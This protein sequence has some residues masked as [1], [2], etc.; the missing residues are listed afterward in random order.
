MIAITVK[1][2]AERGADSGRIF[3]RL[4]S[5]TRMATV[6]S[7]LCLRSEDWDSKSSTVAIGNSDVRLMI[8]R[9]IIHRDVTNLR[10]IIGRLG[11]DRPSF[12]LGD[13]K[14]EF[15][16]FV[17]RYS[18]VSYMTDVIANLRQTGHRRTAETYLTALN[19]FQSFLD[20]CSMQEILIT[21]ENFTI[22]CLTQRIMQEFQSWLITQGLI[23][24][25]IS[26]YNRIL[27]ATYN[28]AVDEGAI[29]NTNPF[30]HVY[31]GVYATMK[32]ALSIDDIRAIRGLDLANYPQLDLARDMFLMSFYLR[33]MSLIDMSF[34]RKSDLV[35]GYIIYHRRKTGQMLIIK[36]TDDMQDIVDKYPRGDSQY[37][38]P[39]LKEGAP[40]SY[41]AY[42]Q[43]GRR[44]NERLKEIATLAGIKSR[45]TLYVARHSWASAARTRGVP[46]SIIS[47]GMGHRSET[48]TRIYLASLDNS[49]IDAANDLI[50]NML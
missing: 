31:T 46:I 19:R 33:G 38:L 17:D 41:I 44:I 4:T 12:T 25:T 11:I 32:R 39:I 28:R 40:D 7:N 15:R 34:L 22:D 21:T 50:L 5:G 16:G 26:F 36:W 3:Y 20:S 8:A 45:L 30:R 49:R 13:V 24:N 42:L 29:L 48:T 9:D 6:A 35:D 37:L 43:A 10:Q 1:F 47:E 2:A 27:R 18:L 23:P 14:S